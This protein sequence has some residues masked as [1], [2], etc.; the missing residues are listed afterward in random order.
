MEDHEHP[1]H[2]LVDKAGDYAKIRADLLKLQAIQASS[3][4]TSAL[5][6]GIIVAFL[7]NLCVL[8]LSVGLAIWIGM[9]TEQPFYGFFIAGGFYLLLCILA[10]VFRR[11]WLKQPFENMIIKKLTA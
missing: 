4:L 3:E 11:K 7:V 6:S 8:L 2:A 10:L 9:Y 5:M 1:L